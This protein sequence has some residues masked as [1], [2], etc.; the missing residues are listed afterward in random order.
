MR[1]ALLFDF[2][3]LKTTKIIKIEIFSCH[4]AEELAFSSAG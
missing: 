4:K 1:N 3:F 2:L